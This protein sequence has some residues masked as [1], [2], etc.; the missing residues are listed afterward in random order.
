MQGAHEP[1]N[2][3][4]RYQITRRCL[5]IIAALTASL[6]AWVA[7]KRMQ[8]PEQI[9]AV[10]AIVYGAFNGIANSY[11]MSKAAGR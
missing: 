3:V 11:F 7:V 2:G 5:A 4:R 8:T 9:L 10:L 6:I 1:V